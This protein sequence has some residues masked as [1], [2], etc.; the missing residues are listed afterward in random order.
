MAK[1]EI[2]KKNTVKQKKESNTI[3]KEKKNKNEEIIKVK[4]N[5]ALLDKIKKNKYIIIGIIIAIL[6]CMAIVFIVNSKKETEPIKMEEVIGII[7]YK[8]L[9]TKKSKCTIYKKYNLEKY[10]MRESKNDIIMH[11]ING[12]LLFLRS[13]KMNANIFQIKK[14]IVVLDENGTPALSQVSENINYLKSEA[15]SYIGLEYNAKPIEETLSGKSNSEYKLPLRESIYIEK[16]EY[17]ATYTGANGDKYD[18]NF[19]MDGDY[20][21]CELVKFL[22]LDKK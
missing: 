16:R 11:G 12:K 2:K 17:S 15:L 6:I 3:K 21:V 18:I 19:Y 8:K 20:L 22:E 5:S 9:N 13:K 14:K 10:T 1:K 7:N 4:K